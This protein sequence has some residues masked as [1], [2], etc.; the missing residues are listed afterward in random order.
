[1][2]S[3][4]PSTQPTLILQLTASDISVMALFEIAGM[5]DQKP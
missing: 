5:V 1:M 4:R 3:R 2:A